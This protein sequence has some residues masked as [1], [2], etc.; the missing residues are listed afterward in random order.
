MRLFFE[1]IKIRIMKDKD[2]ASTFYMIKLSSA[3]IFEDYQTD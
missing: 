1:G 3:F 2:M